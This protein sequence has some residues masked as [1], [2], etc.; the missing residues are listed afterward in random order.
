MKVGESVRTYEASLGGGWSRGTGQIDVAVN[1]GWQRGHH[2]SKAVE[3]LDSGLL[4]DTVHRDA[5]N[6]YYVMVLFGGTYGVP[7]EA[8]STAVPD[9]PATPAVADDPALTPDTT[10]AEVTP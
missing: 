1:V 8:P 5:I 7:P 2:V 10:P 3:L 9:V 6:G 4:I